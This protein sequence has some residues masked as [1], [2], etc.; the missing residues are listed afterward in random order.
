MVLRDNTNIRRS[1]R[2]PKQRIL[3]G[4]GLQEF[5]ETVCGLNSGLNPALVPVSESGLDYASLRALLGTDSIAFPSREKLGFPR[6]LNEINGDPTEIM[7]GALNVEETIGYGNL[8]DHEVR[9]NFTPDEVLHRYG[10][11]EVIL[12]K[13]DHEVLLD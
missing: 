5:T 8:R 6:K 10:M 4:L 12:D 1:H 2:K 11:H 7:V 9:T 3:Y 13:N